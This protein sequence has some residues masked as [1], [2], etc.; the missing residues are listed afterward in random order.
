MREN[1]SEIL[2]S[3]ERALKVVRLVGQRGRLTLTE[4]AEELGVSMSTAHRLL[5]T[6]RHAG[7]VRQDQSGAPYQIGPALHELALGA[8]GAVAMRDAGA[9][10]VAKA[11]KE[12]DETVSVVVL[13]GRNARFVE[14]M[15]GARNV[16]IASPLGRVFPAH[17]LAGGRAILAYLDSEELRRRFPTRHVEVVTERTIHDWDDLVGELTRTHS[18]G[19][20]MDLGEVDREI[21]GVAVPILDSTG[22]PRASLCATLPLSRLLTSHDAA[23]IA[24]VLG[25]H[26][27]VIQRR[28][29][30]SR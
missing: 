4:A 16:R 17:A 24:E 3:V 13:E 19:W 7:F 14:S 1:G 8:T 15:D 27:Q 10:S 23:A 12:L 6:C 30:G 26:A 2:Q 20:A 25:E 9:H 11:A 22:E 29:R 21:G 28:L 5:N 18:R